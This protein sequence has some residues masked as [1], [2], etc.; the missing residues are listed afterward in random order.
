MVY[1]HALEAIH[2]NISMSYLRHKGDEIPLQVH[3]L[4]Q[5]LLKVTQIH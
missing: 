1:N 3:I 5:Y 2:H 4:V